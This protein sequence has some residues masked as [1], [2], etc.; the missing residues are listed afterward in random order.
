M[1]YLI[2][3]VAVST[4]VQ[5]YGA[6]EAGKAQQDELNRQAEEQKLAA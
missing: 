1:S 2:V 4:A 6:I 3:A 5:T